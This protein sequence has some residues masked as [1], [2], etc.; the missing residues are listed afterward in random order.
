MAAEDFK[1]LPQQRLTYSNEFDWLEIA[2]VGG[3]MP[4]IQTAPENCMVRPI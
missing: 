1:L 4:N 2:K 3:T